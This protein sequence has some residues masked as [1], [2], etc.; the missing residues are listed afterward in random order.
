[1]LIT[2]DS[3][4]VLKCYLVCYPSEVVKVP[5]RAERGVYKGIKR[6]IGRVPLFKTTAQA[7]AGFLPY[8][9]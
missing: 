1:M 9:A 4:S 3:L 7:I 5:E 2:I 8:L 6:L